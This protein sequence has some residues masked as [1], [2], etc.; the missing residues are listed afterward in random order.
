MRHFLG[1]R[2]GIIQSLKSSFKTNISQKCNITDITTTVLNKNNT[3]PMDNS[4]VC[5]IPDTYQH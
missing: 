2:K 1:T 5:N 3:E 4:L